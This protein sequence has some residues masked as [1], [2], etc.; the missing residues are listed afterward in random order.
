MR[1]GPDLAKFTPGGPDQ[2]L[3]AGQPHLLAYVGVMN[4]QDGVDHAIRALASLHERR[5]DWRAMFVGDGDALPDVRELAGELGLRRHGRLCRLARRGPQVV[6]VLSRGRH[7]PLSRAEQSTQR[8]FDP[9]EDCR[10]H[11]HE[12]SG[13][14]LR[15]AWSHASPRESAAVF[16]PSGDV[17]AFAGRI[18]ELLDDPRRREA[19][20]EA[21]RRRVEREFSW[22]ASERALR[23]AYARALE[24]R[25]FRRPARHASRVLVGRRAPCPTYDDLVSRRS[26]VAVEQPY[27]RPGNA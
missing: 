11:G 10:V 7:L 3:K 5:A 22:E 25:G 19:M 12:M 8:C 26:D 21:G 27:A 6:R 1:N 18:D 17:Q 13:R 9:G 24:K 14:R 23:A 20:G 16:V 2:T 15:S 4:A